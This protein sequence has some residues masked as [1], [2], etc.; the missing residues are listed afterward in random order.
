MKPFLKWAGGKY[1]L[2][3]RIRAILPA[4]LRLIEPFVGSGAVFL[5]VDYDAY[6]LADI[7]ADLM[8]MY[9]TLQTHGVKFIA[10]CRTFFTPENNTSERYYALRDEFNATKNP[11]RKSALFLYLN[12]HGYNGLVRYNSCGRYNVPFG[13]YTRPYFPEREMEYFAAHAQRATFLCADFRTIMDQ[14]RP[15][16]VV[17]CDPPYVPLSATANFTGYAA[18]GFTLNDQQDLVN[19]VKA[20]VRR[21]IPVLV[22]NH[23]T[24]ETARLYAN[25]TLVEHFNVQRN[26]SCSSGSRGPANEVL[27]LF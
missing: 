22:S 24:E 4:G 8:G 25:A 3:G 2:A 13:R 5:N 15:G 21:G 14:A 17:Y 20:L 7:N 10:H 9:Q 6:L 23:D 18:S 26:I 16:D 11:W 12:R 19:L 1:R 27:A